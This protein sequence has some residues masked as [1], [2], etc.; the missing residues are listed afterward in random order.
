M[1]SCS[2]SDK[3]KTKC[4]VPWQLTSQNFRLRFL[5]QDPDWVNKIHLFDQNKRILGHISI[6]WDDE[7]VIAINSTFRG[8]KK[9]RYRKAMNLNAEDGKLLQN[10]VLNYNGKGKIVIWAAWGDSKKLH[11][12]PF[13]KGIHGDQIYISFGK[14]LKGHNVRFNQPSKFYTVQI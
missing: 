3:I 4:P 9:R 5:V 13:D 2:Q 1:T 14:T 8:A 7:S 6:R 12:I 10:V 11:T